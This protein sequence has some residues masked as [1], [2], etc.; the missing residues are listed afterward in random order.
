[1]I[2]SLFWVISLS[3]KS[4]R[5]R[6]YEKLRR[7]KPKSRKRTVG[8]TPTFCLPERELSLKVLQVTI[9]LG[10]TL[11]KIVRGGRKRR[12]RGVT[13]LS[14]I[15]SG[16][17]YSADDKP[18]AAKRIDS[19]R[20]LSSQDKFFEYFCTFMH[21]WCGLLFVQKVL[22]CLSGFFLLQWFVPKRIHFETESVINNIK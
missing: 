8:S 15:R 22:F 2:F 16:I 7:P 18:Q 12:L 14:G 19:C 5:G 3:F 4:Y 21:T 9:R 17:A 11:A 1:M 6:K 20:A 10:S 13:M